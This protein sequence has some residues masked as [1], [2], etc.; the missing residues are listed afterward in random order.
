MAASVVYRLFNRGL[1]DVLNV[2]AFT[3]G[4]YLFIIFAQFYSKLYIVLQNVLEQL[5]LTF[6]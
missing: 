3:E 5:V 2:E 1:L 4:I 6:Y